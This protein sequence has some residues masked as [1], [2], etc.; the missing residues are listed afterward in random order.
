MNLMASVLALIG[1]WIQMKEQLGRL[2]ASDPEG[3]AALKLVEGWKDEHAPSRHPVRWLRARSIVRSL[4][5]DSPSEAVDYRRAAR[6]V[7]AWA[8]LVGAAGMFV[9]ATSWELLR[10]TLQ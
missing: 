6:S 9:A 3:Y 5:K 7:F 1:T 8:C 2:S 10:A 4:L